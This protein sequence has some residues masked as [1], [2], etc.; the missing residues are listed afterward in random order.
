[1]QLTK[2]WS[3]QK[4][5]TVCSLY[6]F[7]SPFSDRSNSL[8]ILIF[9]KQ[10]DPAV[11]T[12]QITAQLETIQPTKW[13]EKTFRYR[14]HQHLHLQHR[15]VELGLQEFE[16]TC[17]ILTIK[18]C[19]C[20]CMISIRKLWETLFPIITYTL[21]ATYGEHCLRYNTVVGK[22]YLVLYT[23]WKTLLPIM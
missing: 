6:Q 16:D 14:I 20:H 11:T 19:R 7:P 3:Y 22:N 9:A 5:S 12:K 17:Q 8:T 18:L 15:K 4:S 23:L 2:Q 13:V 1:M 10:S 21:S